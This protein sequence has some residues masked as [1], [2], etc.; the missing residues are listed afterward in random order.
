MTVPF[1]RAMKVT[2]LSLAVT[3]TSTSGS[4]SIQVAVY[5][6]SDVQQTATTAFATQAASTTKN[7]LWYE[8]VTEEDTGDYIVTQLAAALDV[9]E[10]GYLEIS[11]ANAVDASD[12]VV[13]DLTAE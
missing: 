11:D 8:N 9:P 6:N 7:Y 2:D 5:D 10:G 4:R 1:S 3:T 13:A 12:T